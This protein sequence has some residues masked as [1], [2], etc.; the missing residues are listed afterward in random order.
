M[1][2]CSTSS[3][4]RVACA[5]S[6]LSPG[7]DQSYSIMIVRMIL[8]HEFPHVFFFFKGIA[9]FQNGVSLIFFRIAVGPPPKALQQLL[10]GS[11]CWFH[12]QFHCSIPNLVKDLAYH[13]LNPRHVFHV[14][15]MHMFNHVYTYICL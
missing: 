7:Y 12:L 8:P 9:A 1:E 13:S 4:R 6:E 2:I 10:V 11:I 3:L 15:N 5:S 14:S